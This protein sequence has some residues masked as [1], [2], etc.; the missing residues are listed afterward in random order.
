MSHLALGLIAGSMLCL[1]HLAIGL[2]LGARFGHP[3][4]RYV[5][6]TRPAAESSDAQRLSSQWFELCLRLSEMAGCAD[7]LRKVPAELIS[8][9]REE[10]IRLTNELCRSMDLQR[11]S[12]ANAFAVSDSQTMP[13]LAGNSGQDEVPSDE[14]VTNKI[15]LELLQ[16]RNLGFAESDESGPLVRYRFSTKQPLAPAPDGRPLSAEAF[17]LVQLHDLSVRDVRFFL[18]DRPVEDNVVIGLGLPKPVKWIAAKIENYR[19]VFMYGRVGYLVTAR[20]LASLDKRNRVAAE[21]L[22]EQSMSEF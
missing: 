1:I 2:A 14:V 15:I 7:E 8:Q 22:V 12:A 17:N 21:E 5:A 20:L 3:T 10:L 11:S 13:N 6:L 19:S 16:N 18:D 9:W 4:T